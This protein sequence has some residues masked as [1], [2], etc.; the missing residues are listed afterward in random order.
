MNRKAS[1]KEIAALQNR[2]A[3]KQM[4]IWPGYSWQVAPQQS[5]LPLSPAV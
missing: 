3:I 2:A 4:R 1:I 5:L